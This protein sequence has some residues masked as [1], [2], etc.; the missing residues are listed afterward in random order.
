MKNNNS[1]RINALQKH[2]DRVKNQLVTVPE[3]RKGAGEEA[4]KSWVRLEISRTES[5]IAK[6]KS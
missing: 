1:D 4:Y 3:R 2:L 5:A 6:L